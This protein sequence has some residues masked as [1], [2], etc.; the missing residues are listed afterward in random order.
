[1]TDKEYYELLK[2]KGVCVSCKKRTAAK[3]RVKCSICL[4]N[5]RAYRKAKKEMNNKC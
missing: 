3:N 5:D 4:Y 2:T 1:M